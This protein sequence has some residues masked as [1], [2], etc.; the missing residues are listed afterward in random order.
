MC[1]V[2]EHMVLN[3]YTLRR[4]NVAI[5]ICRTARTCN[6]FVIIWQIS[7][8]T[9]ANTINGKGV[10]GAGTKKGPFRLYC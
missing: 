8:S 7:E 2:R 5:L 3:C 6:I 4:P 1:I 10:N 9:L